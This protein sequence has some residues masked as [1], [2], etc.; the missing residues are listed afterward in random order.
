MFCVCGCMVVCV[1]VCAE[2]ARQRI[3]MTVTARLRGCMSSREHPHWLQEF[4]RLFL[5]CNLEF[6]NKELINSLM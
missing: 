4:K 3:A 2:V 5:E 6:L 1:C